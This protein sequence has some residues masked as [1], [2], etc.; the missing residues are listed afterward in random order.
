MNYGFRIHNSTMS[1]AQ[2]YL[3]STCRS[4]SR[5]RF[6]RQS[7]VSMSQGQRKPQ[8]SYGMLSIQSSI[9]NDGNILTPR[10]SCTP[11]PETKWRRKPSVPPLRHRSRD[12]D[13]A[14]AQ[15]CVAEDAGHYL[16]L[17]LRM[18]GRNSRWGLTAWQTVLF[19]LFFL[20]TDLDQSVRS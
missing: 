7:S 19:C 3:P 15:H 18:N 1:C 4:I 17:S 9:T 12:T 6:R 20:T 13:T 8:V 16:S 5:V 14:S 2:G 11:S 10:T